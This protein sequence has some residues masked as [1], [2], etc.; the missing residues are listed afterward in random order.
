MQNLKSGTSIVAR[1]PDGTFKCFI[2]EKTDSGPE[3]VEIHPVLYPQPETTSK[4]LTEHNCLFDERDK[5]YHYLKQKGVPELN[6]E[7]TKDGSEEQE[8]CKLRI[9]HPQ[10]LGC[11]KMEKAV[12]ERESIK[13]IKACNRTPEQKKRFEQLKN[14]IRNTLNPK[15]HAMGLENFSLEHQRA[16]QGTEHV[17]PD[18]L[19]YPAKELYL[20][21][22][23]NP[24][25]PLLSV[26][27]SLFDDIVQHAQTSDNYTQRDIEIITRLKP[28]EEKIIE[29]RPPTPTVSIPGV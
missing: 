26:D 3:L 2:L 12:T 14:Y 21:L 11:T 7:K 24:N 6:Y 25:R 17:I 5:R 8:L 19:Y 23:H 16:A 1:E 18:N 20:S 4:F 22:E 28:F 29:S 15:I 9:E 13:K 27:I 10:D